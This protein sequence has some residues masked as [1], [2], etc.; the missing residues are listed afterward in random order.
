MARR[1]SAASLDTRQRLADAGLDQ[2]HRKGYNGTSVQDLVDAA[3]APKG[4]FYNHFRSKEDLALHAVRRYADALRLD[5]LRD[6]DAGPARARI[7]RHLDHVAAAAENFGP[8]RGCLLA[9][10][11]GEVP[12]HSDALARAVSDV[13]DA[14][15]SALGDA[16][17]EAR[18]AGD[19]E[20]PES[21]AELAAFIVSAYEGAA[22]RAK[23]AGS[24]E[25]MRNFER[26]TARLLV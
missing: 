16:I 11:A 15:V 26:M 14:W 1:A 20:T 19:L 7:R 9:T 23:A 13:L 12:A 25:P 10:L 8:E 24:L 4:T 18:A 6:R 22:V 2:F 21:G 17:D 5:M 3:G